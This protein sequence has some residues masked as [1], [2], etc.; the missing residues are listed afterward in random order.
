MPHRTQDKI[1]D[2]CLLLGLDCVYVYV[3]LVYRPTSYL[4]YMHIMGRKLVLCTN[5]P[6]APEHLQHPYLTHL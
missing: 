2:V 3:C 1:Y 5:A 4:L 6:S